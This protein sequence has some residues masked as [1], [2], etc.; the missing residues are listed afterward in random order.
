V[1]QTPNKI[2]GSREA[3]ADAAWV[4][5]LPMFVGEVEPPALEEHPATARLSAADDNPIHLFIERI[6]CRG[7]KRGA[8][9]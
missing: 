9:R 7:W 5:G 1:S 8:Q 2:V 6:L 3:E 4:D